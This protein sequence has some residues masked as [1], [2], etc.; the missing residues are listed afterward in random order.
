MG[1]MEIWAWIFVCVAKT[2]NNL[3]TQQERGEKL[4]MWYNPYTT[5]QDVEPPSPQSNSLGTY[6]ITVVLFYRCS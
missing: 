2:H 4:F 1:M 6:I 5:L 3:A